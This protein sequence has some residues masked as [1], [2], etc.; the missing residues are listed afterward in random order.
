VKLKASQFIYN[1]LILP[2]LILLLKAISHKNK[3]IKETLAGQ[4]G[5]WQRIESQI[6]NKDNN[7]TVIW[8]HVASAGEFLQALPVMERLMKENYQCALTITSVSGYRWA[9][10]KRSQYPNIFLI[11]YFP[12]DSKQNV[13]RLLAHINP[14]VLVFV[15]FDL[16]PNL[17]WQTSQLKIPQILISATLQEKSKR[18][19]SILGRMFYSTLYADLNQIL[20]VT[21]QDRERFITSCPTHKGI[22]NAGDT[23]FDSVLDRKSNL[24]TP[25]LPIDTT[26]KKILLLGSIWPADEERILTQLQKLLKQHQELLIIFAPHEIEEEHINK[27]LKLFTDFLPVL[28]TKPG[29]KISPQSRFLMIDTVGILSALYKYADVAYVG[30]AFSTGVHNTMEPA[31]MEVP[32]IFG[33][34]YQN[35][36]EAIYMVNHKLSFS[37]QNADEFRAILSKLLTDNK[38]REQTGR[39]AARYIDD[40]AGAAEICFE[41]IKDLAE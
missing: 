30:G 29:L 5:I 36:P 41:K 34:Y 2:L 7:K 18:V 37:I 16:W 15:K 35:S 33:P 25:E 19:T 12:F 3:K 20:T 23:R 32:V 39:N 4:T 38:F 24:I 6:K 1:V 27:V 17:I 22:K 28:F 21:E 9:M 31:A 10:K 8:F 40:Q 11:D 26:N 14:K 13:Q